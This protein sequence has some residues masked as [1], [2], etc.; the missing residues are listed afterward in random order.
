MSKTQIPEFFINA[1]YESKFKDNFFV[2]KVGGKIA[3][4]EKALE[5]LLNNIRDLTHKGIK[6][7]MVYGGGHAMDE[8]ARKNG[9]EV[10][11]IDGRRVT[12]DSCMA[13]MRHVVAGDLSLAVTSAMAKTKLDGLSLNAV[14]VDWLD[15]EL[16]SKKPVDYGYVGDIKGV[17]PRPI[18]RLFRYTNFVA[19]A[20]ITLSHDGTILNVNADTIATQLAIGMKAHKLMFFSDVDGVLIKGKPADV[21]TDKQIDKLIADG[22]ATGGMKVKLQNCKLALQAGVRRIHLL[23]GLREDAL[24]REIYESTGPGTMLFS[25][26]ERKAY[27]NEIE[28]QR[29]IEGKK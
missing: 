25:E 21:I 28:T 13:V 15:V 4:D 3:E 9:I 1:F 7:L 17:N 24:K 27:D 12:T 8:E 10:K 18:N 22:I 23:S 16:R 20:C 6:I 5:N 2:V 26:A 19:C 29:L 11:K 14:P